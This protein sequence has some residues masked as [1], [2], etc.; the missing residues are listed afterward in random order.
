M[1]GNNIFKHT[2]SSFGGSSFPSVSQY[3]FQPE[4]CLKVL[5]FQ[6]LY[7]GQDLPRQS[8]SILSTYMLFTRFYSLITVFVS[9]SGFAS[10][11]SVNTV[12]IHVIYTFLFFDY[13]TKPLFN[14]RSAY[15][16]ESI[17]VSLFKVLKSILEVPSGKHVCVSYAPLN[18]IFI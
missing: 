18:P 10:S 4:R 13:F 5:Y 15:V 12:N 17:N 14:V 6:S 11:I 9:W 3:Y 2:F 1:T 16:F 7:P 8:V